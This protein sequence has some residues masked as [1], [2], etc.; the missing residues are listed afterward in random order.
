MKNVCRAAKAALHTFFVNR[1][2]GGINVGSS[3]LPFMMSPG[4]VPIIAGSRP[5]IPAYRLDGSSILHTF[6]ARKMKKK[7]S[8]ILS[9]RWQ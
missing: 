5:S 7:R 6:S 4:A 8:S 3:R 9:F 2:S 1:S